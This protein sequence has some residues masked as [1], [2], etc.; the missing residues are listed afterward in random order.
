MIVINLIIILMYYRCLRIL[1]QHEELHN[2][3]SYHP[4]VW[5]RKLLCVSSASS[6]VRIQAAEQLIR[7]PQ[8]RY[9]VQ[10]TFN[11]VVQ[12]TIRYIN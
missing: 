11:Y 8:I 1:L 9:F 5:W 7:R 2:V 10:F 3:L 6:S 12:L 4:A